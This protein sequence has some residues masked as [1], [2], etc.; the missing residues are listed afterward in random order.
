MFYYKFLGHDLEYNEA[1]EKYCQL[2]INV[3]TL[4][5]NTTHYCQPADSFL[6]PKVK[7]RWINIWENYKFQSIKDISCQVE[8]RGNFSGPGAL[9]NPGKQLF[10]KMAAESVRRVNQQVDSNGISYA[11]KAMI[12]SG[13]LLDISGRWSIQHLKPEIQKM[14]QEYPDHF[15][16]I[17]VSD[18]EPVANSVPAPSADSV[19]ATTSLIQPDQLHQ[20]HQMINW[21]EYKTHLHNLSV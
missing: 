8:P 10:L 13:I 9:W 7:Y 12:L 16:R 18:F 17:P 2:D 5:P 20:D 19:I 11:R 14:I 21:E 3:K 1:M 4:P 15:N 6:T